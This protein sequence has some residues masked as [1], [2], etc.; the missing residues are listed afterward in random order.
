[1]NKIEKTVLGALAIYTLGSAPLLLQDLEVDSLAI[2]SAEGGGRI[3]MKCSESG[4]LLLDSGAG[5]VELGLVD[6]GIIIR[7]GED[8]GEVRVMFSEGGANLSVRGDSGD[9]TVAADRSGVASAATV[10]G[11]ILLRSGVYKGIAAISVGDERRVAAVLKSESESASLT[12]ASNDSG[13][14]ARMHVDGVGALSSLINDG[15]M[16]VQ[17]VV[18]SDFGG[19]TMAGFDG[20]VAAELII[21]EDGAG[22]SFKNGQVGAKIEAGA[23]G[24]RV[25]ITGAGDSAGGVMIG[26]VEDGVRL[27][28]GSKNGL[29]GE[30]S[31]IGDALSA[32]VRDRESGSKRE[33]TMER[34]GRFEVKD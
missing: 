33:L 5:S 31:V 10:G 20:N 29:M 9:W 11:S 27:R 13:F 22:S 14:A 4:A 32:I 8:C 25:G 7:S 21:R 3:T 2:K 6:G 30:A 19:T 23:R 12:V 34:G 1:M 15:V 18:G 28:M 24:A 26:T 16:Q 17:S